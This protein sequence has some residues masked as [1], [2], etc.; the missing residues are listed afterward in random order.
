MNRSRP[1]S[2]LEGAILVTVAIAAV[3]AGLLLLIRPSD[4][5][6][7]AFWVAVV[8]GLLA[9]VWVAGRRRRSGGR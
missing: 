6:K 8:L 7:T 5:A 3:V 1:Y 2:R 9:N 4:E